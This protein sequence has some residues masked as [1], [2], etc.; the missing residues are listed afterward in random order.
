MMPDAK[1]LLSLPYLTP[2]GPDRWTAEGGWLVFRD[3]LQGSA[4]PFAV[5]LN[6]EAYGRASSEG[7]AL[8]LI[9]GAERD[10]A[11]R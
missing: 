8:D 1:Y 5:T 9:A 4:D 7:D 10:G 6:G 3:G 2:D 11:A